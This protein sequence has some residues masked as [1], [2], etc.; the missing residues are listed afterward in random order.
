M[1]LFI[2]ASYSSNMEKVKIVCIVYNLA[3]KLKGC[4]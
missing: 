1:S 3:T 2:A 4:M